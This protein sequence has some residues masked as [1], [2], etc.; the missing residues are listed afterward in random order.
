MWKIQLL[1][2]YLYF[3]NLSLLKNIKKNQFLSFQSDCYSNQYKLNNSQEKMQGKF[4]GMLQ[5]SEE[6]KQRII[7]KIEY[8]KEQQQLSIEKNNQKKSLKLQIKIDQLEAEI[9]KINKSDQIAKDYHRVY[10]GLQNQFQITQNQQ[11]EK[12]TQAQRNENYKLLCSIKRQAINLQSQVY[13]QKHIDPLIQICFH[14]N[15]L[16][17]QYLKFGVD[18]QFQ[19]ADIFEI[20]NEANQKLQ[21]REKLKEE[22]MLEKYDKK[23]YQNN[24]QL[25][26]Q[27]KQQDGNNKQKKKE[28]SNNSQER[29][30]KQ[31]QQENQYETKQQFQ[32]D[33]GDQYSNLQ[34]KKNKN[35]SKQEQEK[36]QD[37]DIIMMQK[38]N[39]LK[40][41]D[42]KQENQI[43]KQQEKPQETQK[44][45][46]DS[47]LCQ[48]CFE[49]PKGYVA[50][51]CGHFVYCQQCKN[52]AQGQCLICREP[53]QLMIKVF[54]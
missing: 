13:K 45:K 32:Q 38:F 46:D 50:T 41:E 11:I 16:L 39:N 22:R 23:Q 44:G 2:L 49:L 25:Q 20:D 17:K 3:Y 6:K 42:K 48:I 52:L 5:R 31:Q 51:P 4:Q 30:S 29:K 7:Q 14:C 53:I 28:R 10:N 26:S 8:T 36:E 15:E 12:L 21:E 18:L 9:Q 37:S 33:Q 19:Q 47:K 27:Q 43:I 24:Q 40:I 54:Q 35:Q 34:D 1:F